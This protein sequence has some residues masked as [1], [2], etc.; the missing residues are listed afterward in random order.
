MSSELH[1]YLSVALVIYVT[2]VSIMRR[3][4][5]RRNI[6]AMDELYRV[7]SKHSYN[8]AA[9]ISSELHEYLSVA[10]VTY[11]TAVSIVS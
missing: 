6:D 8:V 11:V 5:K 10:L 3:E 7:F 4:T 2:A 9:A 1:E